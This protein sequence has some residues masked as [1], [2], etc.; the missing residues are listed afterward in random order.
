MVDNGGQEG[1]FFLT[2]NIN[3]LNDNSPICQ[4]LYYT[5]TI[6]ENSPANTYV[7]SVTITDKDQGVHG[8]LTY[9]LTRGSDYFNLSN[10]G[11][12]TLL[13]SAD[14][15]QNATFAAVIQARDPDGNNGSCYVTVTIA[16]VNEFR[17]V[18]DWSFY[19]SEIRSDA[20]K[21]TSIIQI[22]ASDDDASK[23]IFYIARS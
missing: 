11:V 9:S 6:F 8:S 14:R 22:Y 20:T 7:T 21:G 19:D 3:N 16:D 2:I 13:Q 1:L 17:P 5:P 4:P 18:F 15:E 12:L 10:T 23:H